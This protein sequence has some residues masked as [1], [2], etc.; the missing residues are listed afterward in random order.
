MK[1]LPPYE[2]HKIADTEFKVIKYSKYYVVVVT[3]SHGD[4]SNYKIMQ[5]LKRETM[6]QL[7][8]KAYKQFGL[9]D[10]TLMEKHT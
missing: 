4:R 9:S 7:K 8:E 10:E 5:T 1:K 2:V 3:T 6:P